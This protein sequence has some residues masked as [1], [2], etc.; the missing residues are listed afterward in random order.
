MIKTIAAVG[1]PVDEV[2]EIKRNRILP[3]TPMDSMKRIS[4]VTGIHGDE[5]EGQYVCF[6]LQRRIEQNKE[7]LTGIVDIYPAMNPLGIDSITRGIPAFDLDMNRL[8]PGDIDGSMLEYVVARIM[9]DVAGSDCVLDIHASNI[10][11]TEIPQIRINELHQDILVPMAE[12]AN[13]DFIWI[14]GDSTVLEST[15]AYSLNH[16]GTPVLVV[17]MGVGMRITR[18]YGDQM[19]DGIFHL[20]K[21][22]G[23]WNG[24]VKSVRKP[25]ISR[26]PED[27][28]YL[29][30]SVGGVFIPNVEHGA[31]LK[32]D[33]IIG[34]IVDPLC[35][36]VLDEVRTPEDGMLF[37]IRDYPVV[38]E[39]SLMGR[40]LKKEVCGY[41]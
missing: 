23:I 24:E 33:E 22:M 12:A 37:T 28:C 19:V 31:K 29:N 7:C 14:H 26:K 30:A 9:E 16:I 15:F 18:T 17:E 25:I 39:G 21:K 6:E 13:V 10:Y 41:E 2:L 11:L 38:V 3:E 4:I 40:L 8:F 27:V 35:G 1:L 5:L 20:M 36:K 32:K 34:Q